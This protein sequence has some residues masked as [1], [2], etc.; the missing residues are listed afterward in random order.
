MREVDVIFLAYTLDDSY[1]RMLDSALYT[2]GNS[3]TK[4]KFNVTIV[5]SNPNFD[6]L[7][8]TYRDAKVIQPRESFNY[9]KY[10]NYGL[11]ETKNEWVIVCNNDLLFTQGWFSNIMVHHMN[12]P[13]VKS[14]SPY[15]PF[16]HVQR[17]FDTDRYNLFFGDRVGYE[18]CGWCLAIHREIIDKCELFDP[19]FTFL[20]QDNDYRETIKKEGY[21]HALAGDSI[22]YHLRFKSHGLI[23]KKE[24]FNKQRE[25][26]VEKWPHAG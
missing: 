24:F 14:F 9:N 11:A 21:T 10:L 18:L 8:F 19:R 25:V 26:F 13:M 6:S 20:Y 2:L 12:Y 3:E 4:Y 15:D 1:Y 7:G 17:D 16:W 23:D 22:V 5:E